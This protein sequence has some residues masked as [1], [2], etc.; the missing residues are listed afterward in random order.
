MKANINK[1]ELP[2]TSLDSARAEVF[3]ALAHPTRLQILEMLRAGEICVCHIQ[4]TLEL[5]QAYISQHLMELRRAGLVTSRKE[6]KRVF[7]QVTDR[8]V[9]GLLDR[10]QVIVQVQGRAGEAVGEAALVPAPG[11]CPCPRCSGEA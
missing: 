6:G 2:A 11:T 4:A 8:R 1:P 9:L 5:R 3:Q 10:A 7:Y